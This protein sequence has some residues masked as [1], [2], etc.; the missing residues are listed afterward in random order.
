[1]SEIERCLDCSD[2]KSIL[3]PVHNYGL[4]NEKIYLCEVCYDLRYGEN[5]FLKRD[6]PK[7]PT[8]LKLV[9]F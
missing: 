5:Y 7:K 3:I 4:F 6:K 8:H 1:M 2:S 9:K